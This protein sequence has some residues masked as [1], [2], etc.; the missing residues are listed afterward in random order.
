[1]AGPVVAV[2]AFR[3]GKPMAGAPGFPP[4]SIIQSSMAM[5]ILATAHAPRVD[6]EG[7]IVEAH[8]AVEEDCRALWSALQYGE[9]RCE[10]P[11]GLI[12]GV[13]RCCKT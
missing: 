10:I 8:I 7:L 9:P 6:A 13:I 11:R 2:T 4:D 3:R 12:A 5:S 1:M